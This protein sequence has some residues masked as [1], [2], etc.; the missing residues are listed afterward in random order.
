MKT[1]SLG[2]SL[3]ILGTALTLCAGCGAAPDDGTPGVTNTREVLGRASWGS[4]RPPAPVATS[5]ERVPPT[6]GSLAPPASAS[7]T[8]AIIAAARTPDG[9]AIPQ[10]AGPNGECAPVVALLGFWSC[11]DEGSTCSYASGDLT[12]DCVCDRVDGE[13]QTPAWVCN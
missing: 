13:G 4:W 11:P 1:S 10:P 5:P 9:R 3:T 2:R 8:D 6:S 7:N 12:H